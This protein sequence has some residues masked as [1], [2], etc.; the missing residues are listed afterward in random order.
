VNVKSARM[1]SLQRVT[2]H[3]CVAW[4]FTLAACADA[5][6]SRISVPLTA[7]GTPQESVRVTDWEVHL[8]SAQLAFGPLYLCAGELAGSL[9]DSAQAEWLGSAVID[10]LSSRR[11][12][13]GELQGQTGTAQSFMY[14]LGLS[15]SLTQEKPVVSEAAREL[16]GNSV[17]LLGEAV[18]GE[19]AFEFSLALELAQSEETEIGVPI[20]RSSLTDGFEHSLAAGDALRLHFDAAEWLASVDFQAIYDAAACD[21]R[22]TSRVALVSDGQAA[23]ALRSALL[24]RAK[25]VFDWR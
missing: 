24:T 9:C 19:A 21:G 6:G 5:G 4:A 8:T 3:L 7:V 1:K 11:Q 25:P 2:Q 17:V 12:T 20:V 18:N 10:V 14:D 16:D 22:C 15:S 13:L 23:R